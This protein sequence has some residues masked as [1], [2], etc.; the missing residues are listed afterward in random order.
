MYDTFISKLFITIRWSLSWLHV[1][2][3]HF[4]GTGVNKNLKTSGYKAEEIMN[5]K[6]KGSSFILRNDHHNVILLDQGVQLYLDQRH[7]RIFCPWRNPSHRHS[8][9]DW[10]CIVTPNWRQ[11]PCSPQTIGCSLTSLSAIFQLYS[12]AD[13]LSRNYTEGA[14][15]RVFR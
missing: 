9:C 8:I 11:T 13:D 3:A 1:N 15:N 14:L 4:R 12:D 5:G 10:A 2:R 7:C 6:Q